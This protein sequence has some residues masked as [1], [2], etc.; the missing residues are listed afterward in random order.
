MKRNKS[1]GFTLIE[2][3]VVIAIIGI[4]ATLVLAALARARAKAQDTRV[5]SGVTQLRYLSEIHYAANDSSYAGFDRCIEA[6]YYGASE[7]AF[8]RGDTAQSVVAL[9][10]DII[11]ASD[12]DDPVFPITSNVSADGQR[13]CVGA[14]IVSG[15]A[16]PRS[17]CADSRGI[18]GLESN[19]SFQ[20]CGDPDLDEAECQALE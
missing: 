9:T 16:N 10:N 12:F 5:R 8:C 14:L 1:R 3:L 4:L 6:Y 7:L 18:S 19:P 13:F 11:E 20:P 2:L 17:F 15:V